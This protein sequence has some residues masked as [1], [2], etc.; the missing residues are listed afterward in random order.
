MLHIAILLGKLVSWA[1]KTFGLGA[2]A[3]WPGEIALRLNPTILSS[4]ACNLKKGVILVAGTNGKTT[5]SKMIQ[6]ILEQNGLS[7]VHN[8]SGANLDNGI[9]SALIG[10]SNADWGVFEVDENT[11]PSVISVLSFRPKSRNPEK[12][13]WIPDQVRDDK[14]TIIVLLNIFR[15]QLDRYGEV[16]VIAQKWE[17]ALRGSKATII[18]NADDPLIA[19]LGLFAKATFFGINDKTKFFTTMEHA[20]DSTFCLNCGSRLKYEGIYFSHLGIWE[21]TKCREK[22]PKPNISDGKSPLPGLYNL[23]NTLAAM[24][25][26][27][28]LGIKADLAG[29]H[30]AFGRQEEV[31]NVKIFLSKNPAGFNQS[32]RTVLELGAKNLLFVLNDRIPDGRDVSWIWDVDF[33]MIPKDVSVRVS[34]DRVYDLALRLK[35]AGIKADIYENLE[36]ALSGPLYVLPTYS[37][38]LE[39]RKILKGRKIL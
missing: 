2:G 12:K 13:Q 32:L 7:V 19:H 1:S 24:S 37:A 36:D 29:F 25:V 17:K 9:V 26:A 39:V 22:R 33:E 14:R 4:L 10:K 38:M 16:D 5:T 21:C 35:Y 34:G 11:L 31:G 23:Y 28:I 27:K 3:T 8:S 20:T 15:D 6:I 30:P 18:A